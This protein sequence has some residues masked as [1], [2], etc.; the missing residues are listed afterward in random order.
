MKRI[1]A[2]LLACTMLFA[3][4]ALLTSA[5]ETTNVA[6]GKSYKT[7]PLFCQVKTDDGKYVWSDDGKPNYPDEDGNPRYQIVYDAVIYR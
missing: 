4:G 6:A 3:V 1:A 7:T 5:A 2:L